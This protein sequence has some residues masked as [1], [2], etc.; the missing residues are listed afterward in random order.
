MQNKLEKKYRTRL[1]P[2]RT[3]YHIKPPFPALLTITELLTLQVPPPEFRT[4]SVTEHFGSVGIPN[5]NWRDE[6]VDWFVAGIDFATIRTLDRGQQVVGGPFKIKSK[7]GEFIVLEAA[8][9]QMLADARNGDLKPNPLYDPDMPNLEVDDDDN[10]DNDDDSDDDTEEPTQ[11]ARAARNLLP[12]QQY[13]VQVPDPLQQTAGVDDVEEIV[14]IDA[15]VRD[16]YNR[17]DITRELLEAGYTVLFRRSTPSERKSAASESARH[18]WYKRRTPSIHQS[19][20][21]RDCR[22]YLKFCCRRRSRRLPSIAST[23]KLKQ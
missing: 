16:G 13:V 21:S 1:V 23:S 9:E 17:E 7:K 22:P 5:S 12:P 11:T 14:D 19:A 10:D 2:V 18:S 20:L 3:T 15:Y 6:P 4:A 8:D